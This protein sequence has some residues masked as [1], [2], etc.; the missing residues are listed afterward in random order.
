MFKKLFCLLAVLA[1]ASVANA[2]LVANWNFNDGTSA[3]VS[4]YAG[5]AADGTLVNGASIVALGP[6][7]Y[8]DG[9]EAP[10]SRSYNGILQLWGANYQYMD[11]GGS[12]TDG[13]KYT[14]WP[15]VGGGQVPWGV[16][17]TVSAWF[18]VRHNPEWTGKQLQA[19]V[20]T[21]S[22]RPEADI[23]FTLQRNYSNAEVC[24]ATSSIEN[25]EG[26]HGTSPSMEDHNWHHVVATYAPLGQW[27]GTLDLYVD[28][29][30]E[31]SWAGWWS[32]NAQNPA[33]DLWVGGTP[34]NL[35]SDGN[36]FFRMNGYI[37][38]VYIYDEALNSQQVSDLYGNQDD[39]RYVP[40]P[41]TIALLGLGGLALLRRKR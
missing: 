24:I 23:L 4:G 7:G 13:W 31:A 9:T 40:E 6:Q 34:S 25:W 12:G 41:A 36:P 20:S 39:P 17:W 26:M 32:G 37:D 33:W 2:G 16:G 5:T 3:N 30:L 35:N 8:G 28:T 1:I 29:V 15:P 19:I 11:C 10:G 14:P 27:S 18:R 22:Q 21:G 38:N